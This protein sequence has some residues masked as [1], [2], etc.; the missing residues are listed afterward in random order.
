MKALEKKL[1]DHQSQWGSLA[2][3]EK[4]RKARTYKKFIL[5][6]GQKHK[7]KHKESAV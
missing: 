5:G 6:A 2:T 4:K 3:I 7:Y 1:R